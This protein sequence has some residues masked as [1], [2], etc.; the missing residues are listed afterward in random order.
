MTERGQAFP[1]VALRPVE[2]LVERDSVDAPT[3]PPDVASLS[4]AALVLDPVVLPVR[5]HPAITSC[6]PPS[7][8]RHRTRRSPKAISSRIGTFRRTVELTSGS[9]VTF[10]E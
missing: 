1:C 6:S 9:A 3:Q 5:R 10:T 7:V 4:V 2:P 8:S